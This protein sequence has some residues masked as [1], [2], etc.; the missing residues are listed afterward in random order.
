LRELLKNAQFEN[1]ELRE[2]LEKILD[3]IPHL[4]IIYVIL[5]SRHASEYALKKTKKRIDKE[6]KKTLKR[7]DAFLASS[8][9]TTSNQK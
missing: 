1:K 5:V 8:P 2:K 6:I 9:S 3:D 4:V 7:L